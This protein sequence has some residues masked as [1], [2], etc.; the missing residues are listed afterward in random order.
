M[1]GYRAILEKEVV[2]LWR[3]YRLAVTCGLFTLLGIAVPVLERYLRGITRLFGRI[4]PELGIGKTGVPDVIEALV[5][6]LWLFG[7]I[8]GVLLLMGALAGERQ[9]RTAAFVAAKPVSRAAIVWAKFVAAAMVLGLASALAVAATWLYAR[10][11]FG[12]LEVMPWIQVWLLA[13][14]AALAFGA[15]TLAASASLASPVGAAA[16]GLAAFAAVTVASNVVTLDPWLPTGL[17]E[18]GQALVLGE[19]GSDLDPFRTIVSTGV[20]IVVAVAFAWMRFRRI[21]L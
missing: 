1:R 4:D 21:D 12:S 10:I 3:T 15:I 5:H 19:V 16:V 11:L 7:P 14:L 17:G 20:V 9:A 18:V 2:E 8:A 6:V 13:W